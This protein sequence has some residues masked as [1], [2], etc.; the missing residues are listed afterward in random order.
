MMVKGGL[1]ALLIA[2]IAVLVYL[3]WPYKGILLALAALAL[4]S[5]AGYYQG[6]MRR[7]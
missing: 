3:L 4:F 1:Q 7:H 6:K 5:F 2:G